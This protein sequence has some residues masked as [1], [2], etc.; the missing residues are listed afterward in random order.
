MLATFGVKVMNA[1]IGRIHPEGRRIVFVLAGVVVVVSVVL[2]NVHGMGALFK[3]VVGVG[4]LILVFLIMFYR[5]PK[6]TPVIGE[7]LVVAPADGRIVAIEEVEEKEYFRGRRLKLSIFMPPWTPHLN[8]APVS[9]QVVYLRYYAGGYLVALHPKSSEKN[10]RTSIVLRTESGSEVLIRQ[11]AGFIARR[12]KCY[13]REGQWVRQGEDIGFIKFGSRVDL[14]LPVDAQVAV[15]L[16]QKVKAGKTILGYLK[17]GRGVNGFD[18]YSVG[19][20][21]SGVHNS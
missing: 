6:R 8:K 20:I 7:D 2:Y 16:H 5:N 3:V 15:D 14:Y 12:V 1:L 19:H 18:A 10:E 9:G 17:Q 11:V 4:A 21:S 13:L